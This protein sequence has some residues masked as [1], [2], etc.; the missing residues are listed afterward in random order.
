LEYNRENCRKLAEAVVDSW[1]MD[2]LLNFAVDTL[3]AAYKGVG[4]IDAFG[5][6]V[7]M[8]LEDEDETS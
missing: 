5:D 8:Y 7:E 1:D 4:G 2:T 6:D 3:E